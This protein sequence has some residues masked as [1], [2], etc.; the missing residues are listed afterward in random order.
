[1]RQPLE[2]MAETAARTLLDRIENPEDWVAEIEVEPEFVVR[3]STA[4]ALALPVARAIEETPVCARFS[5]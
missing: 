2:I 5:R 1:V 4:R 3:N